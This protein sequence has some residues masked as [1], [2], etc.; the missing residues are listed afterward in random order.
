MGFFRQHVWSSRPALVTSTAQIAPSDSDQSFTNFPVNQETKHPLQSISSNSLASFLAQS[1]KD[2]IASPIPT[3]TYSG[4]N[5][6]TDTNH[7]ITNRLSAATL[8]PST[9]SVR[10]L[11]VPE[12]TLNEDVSVLKK[13]GLR[14]KLSKVRSLAD[15]RSAMS[16]D[17]RNRSSR[18]SEA[19]VDRSSFHSSFFRSQERVKSPSPMLD[20]H[21][22]QASTFTSFVKRKVSSDSSMRGSFKKQARSDPHEVASIPVISL[23]L[24]SVPPNE[25]VPSVTPDAESKDQSPTRNRFLPAFSFESDLQRVTQSSGSSVQHFYYLLPDIIEEIESR[26]VSIDRNCS[27]AP[28][29]V[30]SI[31]N[32]HPGPN[33]LNV[34]RPNA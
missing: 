1:N 21:E 16:A 29:P 17:S 7:K 8:R 19:N 5:I 32:N 34:T 25:A 15:V 18:R 33:Q 12:T 20:E 11:T 9:P 4:G 24:S 23:P 22:S 2:C 13:L 14:R 28:S 26:R 30:V 31:I 3:L 27:L 10:T 6:L